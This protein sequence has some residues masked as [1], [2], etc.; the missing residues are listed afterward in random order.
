M[1]FIETNDLTVPSKNLLL[2]WIFF[3]QG[4][5]EL[6]FVSNHGYKELAFYRA[7]KCQKLLKLVGKVKEEELI[8]VKKKDF[9]N[10]L[11]QVQ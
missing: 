8:R 3:S 6:G 5:A 4:K 10:K 7:R 9:E 11:Q 2:V 1:D